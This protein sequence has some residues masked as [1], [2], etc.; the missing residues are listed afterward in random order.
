MFVANAL[1][2]RLEPGSAWCSSACSHPMF[3]LVEPAR[4]R[5]TGVMGDVVAWRDGLP[6]MSACRRW[7]SWLRVSCS[8]VVGFTSLLFL[9]WLFVS[10]SSA[11]VAS[12]P[13]VVW[14]TLVRISNC[15]F[16]IRYRHALLLLRGRAVFDVR[17]AARL[18][19]GS[20]CGTFGQAPVWLDAL[21]VDLRITPGSEKPIREMCLWCSVLL[22]SGASL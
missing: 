10:A 19:P 7:R 12:W 6:L 15:V 14:P 8:T 21:G 16:C 4:L 20:G 17:S 2:V 11:L 22:F 9:S 5:T 13:P 3:P 1:L 18:L